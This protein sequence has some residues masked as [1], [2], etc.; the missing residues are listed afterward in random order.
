MWGNLA[1]LIYKTRLSAMSLGF[2]HPHGTILDIRSLDSHVDASVEDSAM[3][4]PESQ[5][6]QAGFIYQAGQVTLHQGVWA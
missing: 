4:M 2:R 5:C 1:R 6:I 3:W